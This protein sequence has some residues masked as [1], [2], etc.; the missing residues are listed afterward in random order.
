MTLPTLTGLPIK[1]LTIWQP[2][3][4]LIAAGV[5]QHETRDWQTAYRG[6][7]A[8]HAGRIIDRPGAP[9][10]LC[11]YV[12]GRDWWATCPRGAVVAIANLTACHR[13]TDIRDRILPPDLESGNFMHGRFAFTLEDVRPLIEPIPL[14]GRRLLFNWSPPADIEANL[15]PAI[16]HVETCRRL[17]LLRMAA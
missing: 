9:A 3:A 7:I 5:K 14:A 2:W 17:G 1:A 12:L 11:S 13:T 6:P 8:I 15:D 4:Q 16:D 10:H